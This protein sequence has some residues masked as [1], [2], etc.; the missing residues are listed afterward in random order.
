M[1]TLI[2]CAAILIPL[3]LMTSCGSGTV[4][5][6]SA[7]SSSGATDPTASV[8][9]QMGTTVQTIRTDSIDFA[10]DLASG[11]SYDIQDVLTEFFDSGDSSINFV[12]TAA[13]TAAVD[14][15]NQDTDL[16]VNYSQT[17]DC[18]SGGTKT[19]EGT[20]ALNVSAN[21]DQGSLSG[22]YFVIYDDCDASVHLATASSPCDV[23]TLINGTVT[24][25]ININFSNFSS[26]GDDVSSEASFDIQDSVSATD[27]QFS[28]EQGAT[29]DAS[30]DYTI[31]AN[32]RSGAATSDPEVSG[33][34]T[35]ASQ[36]Y[37]LNDI[38]DFIGETSGSQICP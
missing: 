14:S 27:I 11:S 17:V 36:T 35:F 38:A 5:G 21:A 24:N 25:T 30:F 8:V 10:N 32:T 2:R 20:L 22:N 3:S 33:T 31:S 9:S 23:A 1:K 12:V 18:A 15:N 26:S 4:T 34:T 16:N 13:P 28:I 37:D 6:S 29:R 19:L 7:S